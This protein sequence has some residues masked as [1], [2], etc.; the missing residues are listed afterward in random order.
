MLKLS[1]E[2]AR[3]V[4]SG[5]HPHLKND[6]GGFLP[7][8]ALVGRSN[9]GK[10]SLINALLHSKTLAK[11]S[12]TPGKTQRVNF[13]VVDEKALLVD[14]PGYGYSKAPK[15][16]IQSW[17]QAVDEYLNE[18]TMLRLLLLLIDV[19][20]EISAE[21]RAVLDWAKAKQIPLLAIFTKRDK[22]SR[23]KLPKMDVETMA[24]SNREPG[25]RRQL[26]REINEMGRWN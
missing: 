13:F 25:D 9:V 18:S 23:I 10:S 20:R 11:T 5:S 21:D 26:V 8:I 12:S 14:L 15:K 16:D 22:I 6:Q 17:S 7:E 1:F 2:H 19:R 24:F 3:F 4:S